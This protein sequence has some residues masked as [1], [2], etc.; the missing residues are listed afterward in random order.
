MDN[1]H[2]LPRLILRNFSK[3][4]K[5][6]FSFIKSTKE[7]KLVSIKNSA[8]KNN[9]YKTKYGY[10]L[11]GKEYTPDKSN[12]EIEV[13]TN[14][15]LDKTINEEFLSPNESKKFM[16]IIFNRIFRSFW[17]QNLLRNSVNQVKKIYDYPY[18]FNFIKNN[19]KYEISESE[20]NQINKYTN[21]LLDDEIKLF[22]IP[23]LEKNLLFYYSLFFR[24]ILIFKSDK[25][26]II[27]DNGFCFPNTDTFS[28]LKEIFIPFKPNYAIWIGEEKNE[29]L[30]KIISREVVEGIRPPI[31][32]S[33]NI[34][35][36]IYNIP[37]SWV[38]ILNLKISNHSEFQS[39][40]L[41]E[42]DLNFLKR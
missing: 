4:D 21:D 36:P 11:G 25:R 24:H 6:V 19:Y 30:T 10:E 17:T 42:D 7:I 32:L 40:G 23:S 35:I 15:L 1:N 3:D 13:Y 37:N 2:I 39:F 33:N 20:F 38:E 8:S 12:K 18:L 22:L 14:K 5:R 41:E 26:F 29:Y 34:Q 9:Y 31:Y 28:F 27:S 16:D